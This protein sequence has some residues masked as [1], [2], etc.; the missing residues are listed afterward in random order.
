MPEKNKALLYNDLSSSNSHNRSQKYWRT[1]QNT[2]GLVEKHF[3][4]I[5]EKRT[6][7][8]SLGAPLLGLALSIYYN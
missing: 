6:P 7:A 5:F 8:H 3:A 4:T 1:I 2:F